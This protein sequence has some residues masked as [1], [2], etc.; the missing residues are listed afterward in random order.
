MCCNWGIPG[1]GF[2]AA[3]AVFPALQRVPEAHVLAVA[4]SD[5]QR[6]RTTSL[7]FGIERVY[8]GYQALL[9][10]PDIDAVYIALSNH[11]HHEWT[12]RAAQGE[13]SHLQPLTNTCETARL[14]TNSPEN[15]CI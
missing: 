5:E 14:T 12:I 6:V 11:L 1:P 8:Q 2:V 7:R 9:D 15:K 3:R 4:S 13:A 10:A